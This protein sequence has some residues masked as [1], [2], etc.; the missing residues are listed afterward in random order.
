[1]Y[2]TGVWPEAVLLNLCAAAHKCAVRAAEVCHGRMSKI[3]S[4]Q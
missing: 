2:N 1:M 4:F 3:K